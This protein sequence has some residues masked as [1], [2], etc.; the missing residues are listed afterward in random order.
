MESIGIYP[1]PSQ[2]G[3]GHPIRWR[4]WARGFAF[5]AAWGPPGL[6]VEA[7]RASGLFWGFF[8]VPLKGSLRGSLKV[9]YKGIYKG[10]GFW[11]FGFWVFRGLGF[12]GF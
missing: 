8:R 11:G 3:A 4:S 5:V 2:G 10:L 12:W 1:Y 9:L 7:V 6:W